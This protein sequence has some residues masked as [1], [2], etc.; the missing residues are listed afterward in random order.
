MFHYAVVN[1]EANAVKMLLKL[2]A[3]HSLS[4]RN[5]PNENG[6]VAAVRALYHN[7]IECLFELVKDEKDL[8]GL[9]SFF[10]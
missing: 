5:A 2:E 8:L 4:L 6:I 3:K 9:E 1:N 7:A 10:G